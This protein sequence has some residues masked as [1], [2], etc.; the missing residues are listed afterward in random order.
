MDIF[1]MK[2]HMGNKH[3]DISLVNTSKLR[4]LYSTVKFNYMYNS[5]QYSKQLPDELSVQ[6]SKVE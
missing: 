6:Y 3:V 4:Y 1:N 2:L 5:V